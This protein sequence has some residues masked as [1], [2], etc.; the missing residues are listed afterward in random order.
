M[1][2][3]CGT[4]MWVVKVTIGFIL[5]RVYLYVRGRRKLP[6]PEEVM[7]FIVIIAIVILL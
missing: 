6:T 7:I 2:I 3:E 5:S 1:L 4:S